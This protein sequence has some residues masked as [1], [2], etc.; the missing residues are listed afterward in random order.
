MKNILITGASGMIGSELIETIY[1]NKNKNFFCFDNLSLG[2]M[3]FI[4]KFLNEKNFNFFK[5][6]VSKNLP[7]NILKQLPKK[8]DEIWMLAANS[9][10]NRGNK[11][12]NVDYNST[13]LTTVNTFFSLRTKITKD[14]KIIFTSSSAIYGSYKKTINE[15]L[16][17][18]L[19]ETNY[20]LMK[21]MCEKFLIFH[22]QKIDF[23]LRIY[24]FPN[25]VGR[26][27]THGVIYDFKN[28]MLSKKKNFQVLGNG[29]QK[30]P[31]SFT[32]DI[33]NAMLF[34]NKKKQKKIIINLGSGDNGI[35]VKNIVK[36]FQKIHKMSKKIIY[37]KKIQGWPGDIVKYKYSNKYLLSLGFKFKYNSQKSLE[38]S[39]SSFK[40]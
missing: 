25:V 5:I 39:I 36:L 32:E 30:K 14:T 19:P 15:N 2:K 26:N 34:L 4:K 20:G 8:I 12:H 17:N 40:K 6:D 11:N 31:Y 29:M 3:K 7:N 28:K 10:I 35:N 23:S 9:D 27:L 16:L 13:F 37:E 22:Q 38:K 1:S 18:F 24:R 33:I 21:L